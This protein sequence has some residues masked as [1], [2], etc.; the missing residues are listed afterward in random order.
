MPVTEFALLQLNPG[1]D[2][3]KFVDILKR[4]QNIQ[5]EWV[6]KHQPQLLEGK[7]YT[8]PSN[9]FI[10]RSDPL[11]IVITAPWE[12]P[13]GHGEWIACDE[14]KS[15]M[16]IIFE[17]ITGPESVLVFHLNPAGSEDDLR[18]D[19]F[20][21][22]PLN[23]WRISVK[24]DQKEKL[25]EHYRNVEREVTADPGH[26]IWAGWKI[27]ESEKAEELVVFW[28]QGVKEDFVSRLL[29][30]QNPVVHRYELQPF[31]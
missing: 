1:L 8:N 27:E 6:R 18:G 19:I 23:V 25:Q 2:E 10:H 17:Y 30:V 31:L 12:S 15:E 16:G 5:A 24:H 4:S 20:A 21:K 7:P 14:N 3:A 11:S 22:G 13:E 9:F 28:S 26:R 29:Q